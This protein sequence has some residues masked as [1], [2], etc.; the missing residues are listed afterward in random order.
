MHHYIPSNQS[1]SMEW[2]KKIEEKVEK[3][4]GESGEKWSGERKP[5]ES[6]NSIVHRQSV[7]HCLL[8]WRGWTYCWIS[9]PEVRPSMQLTTA[10]S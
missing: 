2:R 8:D 4:S 9:Y 3:K 6:Q 7:D 10:V 5:H 1:I